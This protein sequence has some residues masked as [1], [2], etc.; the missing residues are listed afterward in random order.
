MAVINV[1][2]TLYDLGKQ[3]G[4]IRRQLFEIKLLCCFRPLPINLHIM[5]TVINKRST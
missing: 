3:A 1:N 5:T 4:T 2:N